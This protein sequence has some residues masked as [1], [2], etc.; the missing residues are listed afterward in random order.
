MESQK[1]KFE[2]LLENNTK[3]KSMIFHFITYLGPAMITRIASSLEKPYN[4]KINNAIDL[5]LLNE[6]VEL[7]N[8]LIK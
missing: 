7:V 3:L 1:T 5:E 8:S 2:S 6:R 4:P